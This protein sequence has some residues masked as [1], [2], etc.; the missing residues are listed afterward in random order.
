MPETDG[1][2]GVVRNEDVLQEMQGAPEPLGG[3]GPAAQHPVI[4]RR[5]KEPGR[6]VGGAPAEEIAPVGPRMVVVEVAQDVTA[7]LG[8]VGVPGP[9]GHQRQ[10][11]CAH[12]PIPLAEKPAY[13]RTTIVPKHPDRLPHH[14]VVVFVCESWLRAPSPRGIHAPL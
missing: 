13:I 5:G 1:A 8:Q 6:R 14:P 7:R 12:R 10:V 9:A 2:G 11:R 4:L 3:A